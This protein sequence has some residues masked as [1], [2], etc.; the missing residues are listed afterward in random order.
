[1]LKNYPSRRSILCLKFAKKAEKHVKFSKWFFPDKRSLDVNTRN[2]KTKPKYTPVPSRKVRYKKS[3]IP[4]LT[5]I[6]N[7]CYFM[8]K[9]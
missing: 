9:N 3:P 5:D 1:M 8:K 4:Y 6:L 7:E 2:S